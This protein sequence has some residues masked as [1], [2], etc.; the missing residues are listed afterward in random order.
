MSKLFDF[1]VYPVETVYISLPEMADGKGKKH[2]PTPDLE[3]W[4]CPKCGS[5]LEPVVYGRLT[6]ASYLEPEFTVISEVA[7]C[8][9]ENCDYEE[10]LSTSA[11]VELPVVFKGLTWQQFLRK[12]L[13]IP[14]KGRVF[15]LDEKTGF[16]P[17]L[18][19]LEKDVLIQIESR[20]MSTHTKHIIQEFEEGDV[21][22]FFYD[23]DDQLQIAETLTPE[24]ARE[25]LLV[26]DEKG[27]VLFAGEDVKELGLDTALAL[28]L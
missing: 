16:D 9:N 12:L 8:S 18:V 20:S 5:N 7:E 10:D 6:L 15:V 17:R 3:D 19:D 14:E 26:L 23:A 1:S 13:N 11:R 2:L 21:Y 28:L 4:E 27:E 22:L 25:L 24:Q